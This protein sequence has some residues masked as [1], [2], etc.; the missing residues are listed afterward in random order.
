MD[1]STF[2]ECFLS[3]LDNA[4]LFMSNL[5]RFSKS[6]FYIFD[7]D[8]EV[9]NN[10]DANAKQQH[11]IIAISPGK[12]LKD[13]PRQVSNDFKAKGIFAIST[14]FCCG[15]KLQGF[16][17]ASLI[18]L[19]NPQQCERRNLGLIELGKRLRKQST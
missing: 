16:L 3:L 13:C 17:P 5:G 2:S 19:N 12:N 15:L 4:E 8:A 18:D 1:V 14:S 10:K 6:A 11:E 9:R 7:I